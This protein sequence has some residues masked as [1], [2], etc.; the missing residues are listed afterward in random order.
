MAQ[1]NLQGYLLLKSSGGLSILKPPRKLWLVYRNENCQLFCYKNEFGSENGCKAPLEIINL[2]KAA[3]TPHA[4]ENNR[5]IIYSEQKEYHL[6]ADDYESMMRW[7]IDLQ[8]RRD[9][10]NNQ[11]NTA[12]IRSDYEDTNFE[13]RNEML[14]NKEEM[15][16]VLHNTKRAEERCEI[17]ANF[18]FSDY[19]TGQLGSYK[20]NSKL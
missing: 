11:F 5:F 3:I 18:C 9:E 19:S 16:I 12:P 14:P 10:W 4:E 6:F 15:Q 1:S 7:I 13:N 2:Q 17:R 20:F 8:R